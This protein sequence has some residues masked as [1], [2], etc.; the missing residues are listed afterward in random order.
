M[1]IEKLNEN[2][3]RATL[4]RE[5]LES[6][7]LTLSEFAYGTEAARSL[8]AD[9]LRFASYRLG[10]NAEDTP[11]MVEAVPVSAD[12]IVL[13]VTK[14]PFPEELDTR[15]AQFTDAP[16]GDSYGLTGGEY[17]AADFEPGEIMLPQTSVKASEIIDIA[18]VEEPAS[19]QETSGRSSRLT[20]PSRFTRLFRFRTIDDVFDMVNGLDGLYHGDNSL[21]HTKSGYDLVAHIGNHS[22]A[23]FNRIVN[24]LSEYGTQIPFTEG[25]EHYLYEHTRPLIPGAA[26][27]VLAEL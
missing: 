18:G 13:I 3:I 11:L 21:Y 8:F 20:Q 7:H 12:S 26:V 6:R 17:D 1:R 19:P 23:E 10:F 27:Q 25:T 2:Q 9:L 16:D 15:F 22:A 14:V 4:T 5:D 24:I